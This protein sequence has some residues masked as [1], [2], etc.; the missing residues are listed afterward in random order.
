MTSRE[1]CWAPSPYEPPAFTSML[2]QV[3]GETL[4]PLT[5]IERLAGGNPGTL[6]ALIQGHA[7]AVFA[8]PATASA[9]PP[10]LLDAWASKLRGADLWIAFHDE[11]H[12]DVA[13]FVRLVGHL[14]FAG[15]AR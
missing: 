15:G 8:M 2:Y 14:A 12:G 7:H 13:A 1:R 6:E 5:L 4:S 9:P 3:D 10:F 11:C